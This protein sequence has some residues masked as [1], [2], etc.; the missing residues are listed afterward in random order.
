[1]KLRTNDYRA[2]SSLFPRNRTTIS[3]LV[4][5]LERLS[6]NIRYGTAYVSVP[7]RAIDGN[8]PFLS[9]VIGTCTALYTRARVFF[10]AR[11]C[12]FSS[13]R[14]RTPEDDISPTTRP[15][16]R[17][18]RHARGGFFYATPRSICSARA[19]SRFDRTSSSAAAAVARSVLSR[20]FR[21]VDEFRRT[22]TSSAN[23]SSRPLA[24]PVANRHVEELRRQIV[25]TR[26][27]GINSR[28]TT[29]E[30]RFEFAR[31]DRE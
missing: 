26:P 31:V 23:T 20:G 12:G 1:M 15:V 22:I 14:Y 16:R 30:K 3:T 4:L 13:K 29:E 6:R 25:C 8:F 9:V 28:G 21:F 11:R 24:R 27:I 19:G 2:L 7:V 5:I 18:E 10:I 17:D